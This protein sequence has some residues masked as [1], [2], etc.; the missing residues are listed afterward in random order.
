[1]ALFYPIFSFK[2]WRSTFEGGDDQY[3]LKQC[4]GDEQEFDTRWK[5]WQG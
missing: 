1:M 2:D 5:I 3:V 4:H